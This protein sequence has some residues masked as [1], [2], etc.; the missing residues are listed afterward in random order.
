MYDYLLTLAE[1]EDVTVAEIPFKSNAKGLCHGNIIGISNKIETQAEK[2]CVLAEE[3]GHYFTGCGDIIN[4][5]DISNLKQEMLARKWAHNY[6]IEIQDII[7]AY[8]EGCHS[9]FEVA[10]F[11]NVTESFLSE[12]CETFYKTYGIFKIEG[13]YV[14]YFCPLAIMEMF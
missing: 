4:Q 3:L 7:D 8:K 14:I 10:E 2:S 5:S 12:A 13:K 9:I 11:L 6:L 1:E